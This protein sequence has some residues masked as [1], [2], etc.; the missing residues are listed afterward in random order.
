MVVHRGVSARLLVMALLASLAGCATGGASAGT[1]PTATAS[2]RPLAAVI[3]SLIEQPPLHRTHWGIHV[4]DA[5]TGAVVY[6]RAAER[7]FIPASNMKLIVGAVALA[8]FGEEYRYRTDVLAA[9]SAGDSVPALV[10]LGS[11]DPTWSARFYP[12]ARTPLDSLALGVVRSGVRRAG[13]LIVDASRFRDDLVH[14]TWEVGD[15]TGAS[16]PPVDAVAMGESMFQL[17]VMGGASVGAPGEARV[18]GAVPQPIRA[19]VWTDTAGA[20][21]TTNVDFTMRR[22]TVFLTATAGM[23][24]AD[25]VSLAVTRPAD[26][27]GVALADALRAA[28]VQVGAV[29]VVRDSAAAAALRSATSRVVASSSSPPMRDIVARMLAPSQ[30]WIAEQLLKSLGAQFGGEGS[31]RAGLAVERAYL[32]EVARIDSAAVNLRDASGLSAQ[33]LLT[34]AAAVALLAHARAQPWGAAFRAGLP[35]P[36]GPGTLSARLRPLEGRLAAKTGTISNV[37]S[38]SGYLTA[39]DGRELIFGVF[40]NGSGLPGAVVRTVMDSVVVAVAR[41]ARR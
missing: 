27:T 41:D 31:W 9:P 13:E 10:V 11:G 37:N 33:N 7:H 40:T 35:V 24:R 22:D 21:A 36:G 6:S 20:R 17:V 32:V 29:R 3:D 39:D 5:A 15:L 12:S 16:G 4:V 26:V 8:R 34:P 18:I 28:G 25:T 30:N 38:L 23:N 19:V 14:F 1:T 2:L